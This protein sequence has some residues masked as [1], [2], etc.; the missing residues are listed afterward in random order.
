MIIV[1]ANAQKIIVDAN[2]K[3]NFK[4]IQAA[5]NSLSDSSS[6]P[7]IIFIKKG[8]YNEKIFITKNNIVLKGEDKNTVIITQ[9][10]ARDIWRC[11]NADDWG[12]ATLNLKGSD[13]TLENLT[14]QNTY[15]YDNTAEIAVPCPA[16]S[17]H[18]KKIRRDGHQMALRSFETT[19]LKVI[20]CILKAFG[21]DTVSPWNV[22]DGMFYF[23]DCEMSGGV[24][25]YCPR[26]WAWA[27]NCTFFANEG[28]ASIWH[29]GSK[30][31]DSKTVLKNCTFKGY[32]GFMLGRYHHDAQFFLIDCVFA[33]NMANKPIYRVPT[34]NIIQW[35]E[36]IYFY[37]CHRENGNDFDWYKNNLPGKLNANDITVNWLFNNRWKP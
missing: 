27:E 33:G 31:E 5:I 34:T 29:D 11:T 6:T 1:Q 20:N 4:S 25:F 12:V 28:P 17:S 8:T 21:G 23:K 30:Y 14:I 3:G 32:D 19:R 36:R 26:G 24:D 9:S 15:G 35:G 7:K 10:I 37:N 13:I 2:G 16:D 22:D 18:Q